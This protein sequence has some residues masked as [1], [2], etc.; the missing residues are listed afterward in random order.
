MKVPYHTHYM[1]AVKDDLFSAFD[2]LSSKAATLPLYWTVTG[3]ELDIYRPARRTGGK[4][5]RHRSLPTGDPPDAGRRI[6][7]L[8]RA[9]AA[10]CLA[11]SILETADTQR[12]SVMATQRRDHDDSRTLLNC[13][14][15]LHCHGHDVAW[16]AVH[17]RRGGRLLKLP[18]YPWQT[19]RFWHECE[20]AVEACSQPGASPSGQSVAQCIPPGK[21]K[22]ALSSTLSSPITGCREV[23]SCPG[24]CTSKWPWQRPRQLWVE[25]Q[26]GQPRAAPRRP[27]RR[28]SRPDP[29]DHTQRGRRHADSLRSRP[30]LTG[31]PH[32]RSRRPR[33]S[34]PFRR[35]R[36]VATRP[37]AQ[38]RSPPSTVTTSTFYPCHR[39]R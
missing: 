3:E 39:I 31:N 21:P 26:R 35:R 29:Q 30:R 19:K 15:A 20:E 18:S 13:V 2:G 5:P 16:D 27:T 10:S 34:T 1:E 23:S 7:P 9:G 25:P 17:S 22:S 8:R 37:T 14:G 24:R 33:N 6:H 32:G 11:A 28:D 12:V 36:A 38:S 4:H